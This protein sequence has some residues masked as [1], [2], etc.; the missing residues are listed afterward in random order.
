[1]AYMGE[2]DL[3]D[4]EK[5]AHGTNSSDLS[6]DNT[7]DE[8]LRADSFSESDAEHEQVEAMDAGHQEDLARQRVSPL[9]RTCFM[10]HINGVL[11]SNLLYQGQ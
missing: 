9:M 1:M 10:K 5:Q 3:V 6:L 8:T 11:D 2:K 4:L 7:A